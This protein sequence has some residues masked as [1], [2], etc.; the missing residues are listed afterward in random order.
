[1]KKTLLLLAFIGTFY[2]IK[3]QTVSEVDMYIKGKADAVIYYDDDMNG[4]KMTFWVSLLSQPGVGLFPAIHSTREIITIDKIKNNDASL[5]NN[6]QYVSGYI[7]EA[8]KIRNK[9]VWVRFGIGTAITTALEVLYL[10]S[11][12]E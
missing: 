8:T 2:S 4:K 12:A 9:E 1:M 5:L 11:S 6:P 7:E 10:L 3:C